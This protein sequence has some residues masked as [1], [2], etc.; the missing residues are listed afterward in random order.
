MLH[1]KSV[2]F[3]ARCHASQC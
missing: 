3:I 1:I 2:V